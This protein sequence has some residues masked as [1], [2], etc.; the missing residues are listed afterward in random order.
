MYWDR[1]KSISA[2][3]IHAREVPDSWFGCCFIW[4]EEILVRMLPRYYELLACGRIPR[5]FWN[6]FFNHS[7]P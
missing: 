1:G 7:L 5:F 3:F 6:R 4:Q 2:A